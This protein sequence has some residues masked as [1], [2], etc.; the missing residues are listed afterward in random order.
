MLSSNIILMIIFYRINIYNK[1]T[2]L[3]F[4]KKKKKKISKYIYFTPLSQPME[5]TYLYELKDA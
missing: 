3:R 5:N 4:T 2:W 1:D